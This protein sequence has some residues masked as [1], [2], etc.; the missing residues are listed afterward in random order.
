M[1][2]EGETSLAKW[3]EMRQEEEW[4]WE[5]FDFELWRYKDMEQEMKALLQIAL[6]CL[7]PLPR[8]RPKM[9]MMHKMIEDI[10]M[11]GGQK[12]GVVL[13]PLSSG[14]SSQSESTPNFTSS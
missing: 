4:T 3:V 9:S 10:R 13:S 11:K 5:V 8:D 6:L 2:G 1:V 12:D 14:Y 7:A